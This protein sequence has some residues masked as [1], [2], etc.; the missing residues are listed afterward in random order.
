M[1]AEEYLGMISSPA[2]LGDPLLMTQHFIGGSKWEKVS[3]DEVVGVLAEVAHRVVP[4]R[5]RPRGRALG[6]VP[7][8]GHRARRA[9]SADGAQL[10]GREVL[11][12]V[13]HDVAQARDP[14]QKVIELV[15]QGHVGA[16]PA[17]RAVG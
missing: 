8:N 9:A 1:P 16:G 13:E 4:R 2:V 17:G 11:R 10:H 12:L 6:D 7:E 14:S 15:E 3:D 5:S